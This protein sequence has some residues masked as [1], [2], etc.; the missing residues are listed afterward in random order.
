MAGWSAPLASGPEF[1]LRFWTPLACSPGQRTDEELELIFEE[2]L[3]IKAV[4]R[5]SNSVS[6][7]APPC[8]FPRA[9]SPCEHPEE[10]QL[11][12]RQILASPSAYGLE[13][14]IRFP[15]SSILVWKSFCFS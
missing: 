5:L 6:R 11:L 7:Q 4:A 12:G 8:P 9:S 13:I 10:A 2:L 15:A 14:S 1:T 3:H